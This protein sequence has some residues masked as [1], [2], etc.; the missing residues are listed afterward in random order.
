MEHVAVRPR[1]APGPGH[2]DRRHRH[3]RRRHRPHGVPQLRRERRKR[4]GGRHHPGH[5]GCGAAPQR[6]ARAPEERRLRHAA[7]SA[8]VPLT[9]AGPADRA[10]IAG[11]HE[12][13]SRTVYF[14]D[15]LIVVASIWVAFM[16]VVVGYTARVAMLLRQQYFIERAY[17]IQLATRRA[18][19]LRE[20]GPAR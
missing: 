19:E 12:K 9:R 20:A 5:G 15:E 1:P 17:R 11:P 8:S 2:H 14:V 3:H 4:L 13:R 7:D 10:A 18:A 16:V 6:L